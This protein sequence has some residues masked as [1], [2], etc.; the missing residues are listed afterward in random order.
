M[1]GACLGFAVALLFAA[2]GS[3]RLK[4]LSWGV[5]CYYLPQIFSIVLMPSRLR[6]EIVAWFPLIVA[7]LFPNALLSA[8]GGLLVW[9]A[10]Y[11][12][13]KDEGADK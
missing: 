5:G 1:L 2:K 10:T 11:F 12:F 3:S 4:T 9:E 6:E 7:N 8:I 13:R